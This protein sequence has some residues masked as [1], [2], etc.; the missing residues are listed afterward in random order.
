VSDLNFCELRAVASVADVPELQPFPVEV[1]RIC[2][3]NRLEMAV[4]SC[5]A[6][7]L[8]GEPVPTSPG[9]ALSPPTPAHQEGCA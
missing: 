2:A 8:I 6:H 4:D 9:H 3:A 1:H 5:L 7:V